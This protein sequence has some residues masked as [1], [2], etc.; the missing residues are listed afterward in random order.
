MK[1]TYNKNPLYTTV[2][3]DESEKKIFELKIKIAEYEEMV[4]GA[5]FTLSHHDWWNKSI[6]KDGAAKPVRTL[7]DT[8]QEAIKELHPDYW[9]QEDNEGPCKMEQR[10]QMLLDHF[11]TELQSYHCGDCT[12]VAMSCSKCHAER[13]LGINTI[14]G[15]GKHE[16]YKIDGAFGK[17]NEKSLDEALESLKNYKVEPP[18]DTS[19]WDRVGGFEQ[20]IPRWTQ[21]AQGAYQW[22]LKYKEEYFP[23]TLSVS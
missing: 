5:Y 18:A 15:I 8:V 14:P 1:I 4:H 2:E 17:N 13:L 21:E 16:L 20:Y 23:E 19:S 9:C 3:L 11:L 10:V 22:L 12:C 7:E 6:A